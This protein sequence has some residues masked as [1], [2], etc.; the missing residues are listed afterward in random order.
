MRVYTYQPT[1]KQNPSPKRRR[2]K[3]FGF[4]FKFNAKKFWT[5]AFRI[6]AFGILFIALLFLYYAKDLPDPNKL[7]ERD[8]PESTKIFAR[9]GSLL[10]EIHGEA[11]RTQINLDQ[12]SDHLEKATIA[13]EDKDFY[14]HHGLYFK[15]IARSIFRYV[16]N[17]GPSGGG[18]STLTQQFVKNAVLT[19]KQSIFGRKIP[20]A[21]LSLTIEAR[22]TKDEI[23]KLYLNEIPYGRNAYGIEAASQTY[24]GKSAKDLDLAESAYLAAL[25]Q[26][27]TRY[28]PSG[29]NR[30]LLDGRKNYILAQMREQGYINEQEEKEAKEKKVEFSKIRT[31]ISA[32][33]FSLMV[34]DY[35][36]SK[37]G[38]KTLQEGGLKVYTTLDPKLQ[39]IAERS[40]RENVEK[41][42]KKYNANNA[43]LVA[44]DPKTGQIL[45]MVG[46]KDYFG[47]PFPAGCNPGKNCSFEG[48]VNVALSQRQPGSSFK[49]YVYATAF[50][51]DFKYSPASMLVDV[52]TDFGT[53][54]GKNYVPHNY[55]GASYGPLSI[56]QALAG[57]LNISAVKTLA[58]VGV[59]NAV[60]TAH[61]LGITSPLANCGLSLVLGGCEVRLLDHVAAYSTIANMGTKNDKTPILKVIDKYDN[62]LEEFQDNSKQVLDPQSAYELISIMTD[63]SAR[64]FVFGANSPL[65]LPGRVVAAKTGTT[66]NWH[67]GWT[68]GFTPSLAAGVWAGNNDGTFLK[69]G[70]DGVLVAAPI[71]NQFMKEALAATPAENFTKPSGIKEVLVD[72][73]SGK[74]PTEYTPSTKVETFADFS[75]PTDYDDVHVNVP[76]DSATGL[77]ATALTPPTQIVNKI[78]TVLHSERRDNP[79]WEN[80]VVAWALANGYQYPSSESTYIPN[81]PG[82]GSLSVSITSPQEQSTITSLPFQLEASAGSGNGIARLDLSI[83]GQFFQSLTNQPF[84]FKIDKKLN[85]GPHSFAVKAVDSQGNTADTSISLTF[86]LNATI[87]VT[88]P[89]ENNSLVFPATLTAESV[90]YFSQINFYYQNSKGESKL[91]GSTTDMSHFGDKYQYSMSWQ[92]PPAPGNYRI[93]AQTGG[94]E[95]SPKVKVVVP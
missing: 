15:G 55:N 44:I 76:T 85:D 88:D 60:E 81:N 11:K 72:E 34:Q 83:D 91:I 47:D 9:D 51:K 2:F 10:Y 92:K 23:L 52:V 39:E 45:A 65:I 80:P 59:D 75:V 24:F 37:Y 18:G 16:V 32:P 14:N 17:R 41:V 70:A 25:P 63:N 66:Q 89:S 12:I 62:V 93:Y 33:H 95:A 69:K 1:P 77:P 54:G 94:G 6:T 31:S 61:D 57:S 90:N 49:P 3:K 26:A 19:N 50:K 43:A 30:E 67:D 58:L 48:N 28:N 29:P 79:N 82:T 35:L 38:E 87:T 53:Y 46:S 71:W 74:L 27:P 40:V 84:I 86:A 73:L 21:I 22:F 8:V 64:S 78:Y 68:L 20:E 36:A 5:W 4:K 13:I 7:L 42:S 56:R